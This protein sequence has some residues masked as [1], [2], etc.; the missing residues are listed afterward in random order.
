MGK[1]L[2]FGG[3]LG[4]RCGLGW[5]A[6]GH[7]AGRARSHRSGVLQQIQGKK[8]PTYQGRFFLDFGA[9]GRLELCYMW[10]NARW[11]GQGCQK[12]YSQSYSHFA[13]QPSQLLGSELNTF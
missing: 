11:C 10:L 13:E 6:A 1:F 2:K 3:V 5:A 4:R 9:R 12:F 7:I 8:K